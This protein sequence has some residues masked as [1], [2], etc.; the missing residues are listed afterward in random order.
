MLEYLNYKNNGNQAVNTNRRMTIRRRQALSQ[1]NQQCTSIQIIMTLYRTFIYQYVYVN[2]KSKVINIL[3]VLRLQQGVYDSDRK[4]LVA[5]FALYSISPNVRWLNTG[6]LLSISI[7][8]WTCR[9]WVVLPRKDQPWN[10]EKKT[11]EHVRRHIFVTC[12]LVVC[13]LLNCY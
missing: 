5:T 12:M 3:Q 10:K 1:L 6:H 4:R 7:S 8:F 13:Y 9:S 11:N 2:T